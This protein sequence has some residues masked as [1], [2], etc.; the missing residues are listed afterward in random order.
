[1]FTVMDKLRLPADLGKAIAQYR[2]A[3]KLSAVAVASKAGRSRT[4]LHKLE[5]GE[6]VT[7]ASLFN[8]LRAMGLCLGLQKAGMPTLE[9][10]QQRFA[11]D[12]DDAGGGH[13]A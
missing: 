7:V 1:M 4:V 3:H 9:E 10:M 8:I 11:D 6:D 13:A 2:E 5:R 12:G